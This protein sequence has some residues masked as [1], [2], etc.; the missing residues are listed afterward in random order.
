MTPFLYLV[1]QDLRERFGADLS[2]MVIVF[3]NKR[4]GLFMNEYLLRLSDGAPVWAPRYL[5]IND[6]FTSLSEGREVND[7]IDSTLR[8]VRLFQRITGDESVNVE[9]FYGWAERILADFEDVDKNMADATSLFRNVGELKAFDDTSF[10]SEEQVAE[11]QKFFSD[12]RPEAKSQLREKF[13]QLW[14]ALGEMYRGLN[15]ELAAENKAYEGALYRS[16]AERLMRGEVRVNPDVE[17]FVF[18]GFNVLDRVEH[19]LFKVLQGEGRALFYW[20]YDNY[21]VQEEAHNE[22]GLFLRENL[23]AFPNALRGPHFDNLVQPKRIEMVAASTEAIQAQY[24]APWLKDNLTDDPK[25]TAVVLCNENLLQPVLHSLPDTIEE[26]NVTKG[27][28]L[29]RTAVVTD[30]EHQM[31]DW[32]RRGT[33]MPMAEMIASL[34]E[35]VEADGRQ[36]VNSQEYDAERFEDI[37]QGEAYFQMFTILNRFAA[38]LGRFEDQHMTIVTL[39]RLL[40]QVV[41]QSSVPFHGEPAAGLQIMGVLETRCLDFERIIML[42]T[43]DGIIPKKANDNSFIPYLLRKAY[44]LTTPERRTAVYAYYFYRL[45]QRSSLVTMTFNN[46]SDGLSTGEMSRFMTQLMVEWPGRV[47]HKSLN[48]VQRAAKVSPTTVDKPENLL[49]QLSGKAKNGRMY[50]SLS[51]SALSDYLKCQIKFYFKYVRHLREPEEV[52]EEMQSNVFGSIFHKAAED[53]YAY[54]LKNNKGDANRELLNAL[55]NDKKAIAAYVKNAFLNFW[56]E[57]RHLEASV[58]EMYLSELLRYDARNGGLHVLG[59]ER[60]VEA[61]EEV[62]CNGQKVTVRIN[63]VIDRLD[64]L[65]REEGDFVRV[66][67]YK[68]GNKVKLLANGTLKETSAKELSELFEPQTTKGYMLQTFLYCLMLQY[69]ATRDEWVKELLKRPLAPALFF[70][71]YATN[72]KY[73]PLLKI[74]STV[75]TDF[76]PFA[77]EFLTRVKGLVAEIIDVKRP[78]EPTPDQEACSRCPYRMVCF[79]REDGQD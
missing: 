14:D 48:S 11:L 29:S 9:R 20:D 77:D 79:K 34:A 32:E 74:N 47:E 23:L 56:P 45:L 36:F 65:H 42:S 49:Q 12:F 72:A 76:A 28:P 71:K 4:A 19:E 66:L 3:P 18:V 27:F 39:R 38:I 58:L 21:Y 64:L 50:P 40:R 52:S 16:V 8:I 1:A 75:V 73:L 24:V 78:F 15:A 69:E 41:R 61:L 60:K 63:G 70:I 54:I 57:Y 44:G 55:A 7:P 67:D 31:S 62:D 46:S 25:R 6:L 59:T 10:L 35:R 30:V 13:Q 51:P 17:H 43:N 53:L 26:L 22:A 33:S 2:R 5:T 68:T 37:L